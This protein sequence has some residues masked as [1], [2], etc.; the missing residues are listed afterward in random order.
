MPAISLERFVT[1]LGLRRN[2]R[3]LSWRCLD[4]TEDIATPITWN[5][6]AFRQFSLSQDIADSERMLHIS[7]DLGL[8]LSADASCG[9]TLLVNVSC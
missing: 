4:P 5:N 9:E 1:L 2:G 8:P 7:I 6:T 3:H